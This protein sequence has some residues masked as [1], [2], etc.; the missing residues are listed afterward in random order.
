MLVL[1]L[2]WPGTFLRAAGGLPEIRNYE[3]PGLNT[4]VW[5]IAQDDDGII[6]VGTNDRVLEYDGSHWTSIPSPN[7]STVRSLAIAPGGRLYFG[8]VAELGYVELGDD[9]RKQ[10]VSLVSHIPVAEREFEDVW[11]TYVTSHGV[12]F[13]AN[14]RLFRFSDSQ[15]RSW[16]PESRFHMSYV[17]RDRFFVLDQAAGLLR[18]TGGE[19]VPVPGGDRFAG[20]RIY[21]MLAHGEDAILIGTRRGMF[22]LDRT[23]VEPFPTRFDD[24]LRDSSLYLGTVLRDG[25]YALATLRSG[26]LVMDPQGRLRQHLR[27]DLGLADD[28]VIALFVD[29]SQALWA[30]TNLGLSR[31]DYPSPFSFYDSR[32]GVQG[33]G[34]YAETH[35]GRTYL[36]TSS[37]LFV[38]APGDSSFEKIDE[39]GPIVHK[40]LVVSGDV[41]VASPTGIYRV[42]G[43]EVSRL[44]DGSGLRLAASRSGDIVYYGLEDGAGWLQRG[45]EGWVD[46]GLVEGFG[47]NVMSIW[48]DRDG[49]VWL[50]TKVGGVYR[51]RSF[52]PGGRFEIRRYSTSEGLPVGR[53]EIAAY[54]RSSIFFTDRGLY[55]YDGARDRFRPARLFGGDLDLDDRRVRMFVQ[56]RRGRTWIQHGAGDDT[57]TDDP[58]WTAKLEIIGV[59]GERPP[60]NRLLHRFDGQGIFGLNLDSQGDVWLGL[61]QGMARYRATYAAPSVTA[62][63]LIRRVVTGD[64]VLIPASL[65]RS[66]PELAYEN[67]SVRFECALTDFANEDHNRFRFRLEGFDDQWSAWTA[68]SSR[69]YTNLPEGSYRLRVEGRGAAGAAAAER[70][71]AF[72]VLAPWYRTA[73]AYLAAVL[74]LIGVF[75]VGHRVLVRQLARRKAQ[76][77]A[78]VHQRTRELELSEREYRELVDNAHDVIFTAN[79]HGHITSL[80]QAG[81][82]LLGTEEHLDSGVFFGSMAAQQMSAF[83]RDLLET[84]DPE[85][86]SPVLAEVELSRQDGETVLLE[87]NTR[88]LRDGDRIG[89]IETIGRDITERRKIEERLRQAQKLEA[90]GELAGGV[91]HDFNNQLT[92]ILGFSELL[93]AHRPD[94]A[95]LGKYVSRI[96]EAGD[97]A[98]RLTRQLLAVGRRQI[99]S[100]RLVRLNA[101][102]APLEAT[103]GRTLGR[104]IDVALDLESDLRA[105]RVD[106]E[107]I[108]QIVLE[109]AANARDAMPEGGRFRIATRNTTVTRSWPDPGSP[110]PGKLVEL[111]VSDDGAGMSEQLRARIFEPFFTTK[112]FGQ[113]AGLGLAGVYGIV[114]QSGGYLRVESRE[115]AGTTF[116]LFFPIAERAAERVPKP[117][118]AAGPAAAGAGPELALVVDDDPSV[119]IIARRA[120]EA[121]F[122]VLEVSSAEEA[123]EILEREAG[124]RLV[125]TDV[126]MP[127]MSGLELAARIRARDS[128]VRIVVM[129]GYSEELL[130]G[131]SAWEQKDAFVA[132]PFRIDEM[133]E[134]IRRVMDPRSRA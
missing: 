44:V 111:A 93:S 36:G 97:Q 99:L 84:R 104:S 87:T 102:L 3:L 31:I 92:A 88:F 33:L 21:C 53:V 108:E 117:A 38:S 9:G 79:A 115:G 2:A 131:R 132:K 27:A 90:V 67:N 24:L 39:I 10:M 119:R 19:L 42:A 121:Q 100:P 124:I 106:P 40:V 62:R 17:V 6:Y 22:L 77:E 68:E 133:L 52:R 49:D 86:T 48:E 105:I 74:A 4:Q 134:V 118:K 116:R 45:D 61:K 85:E 78:M 125:L 81:K 76:L 101:L 75:L 71:F 56:D 51:I 59:G 30:G 95:L 89:R 123:L 114:R 122:R 127:G 15:M 11:K 120:L 43:R 112:E 7:G 5:S 72:F 58:A 37:G 107:Q 60:E 34:L 54:G 16:E 66:V 82:A 26:I 65:S 8:E 14:E 96:R 70:T 109:L 18:T 41:L 98:S 69:S 73:P 91:A 13:Q 12:Y 20:G 63:L 110:P 32:Q 83:L 80:N 57:R 50:G 25:N 29:R 55:S 23:G 129:S 128:A 130:E 94:D 35:R 64:R 113:G 1:L 126:T 47:E 46:G 28:F 103:L